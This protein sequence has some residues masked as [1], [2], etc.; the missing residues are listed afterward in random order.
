MDYLKINFE[1]LR[2]GEMKSTFDALERA[3]KKF[4]IDYYLIGA[5]ARDMWLNHLDYLPERR[6]TVDVDFSVYINYHEQFEEL[7]E[8]LFCSLPSMREE[9][10]KECTMQLGYSECQK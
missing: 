10:W 7:K 2:N 5:Y 1:V 6:A 9:I 3:F 8:Y 4:N